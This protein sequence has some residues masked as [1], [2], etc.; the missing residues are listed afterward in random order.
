M[1]IRPP[2]LLQWQIKREGCTLTVSG[3][4]IEAQYAAVFL[5]NT[6]CDVEA[7]TGTLPVPGRR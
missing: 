6:F 5:D 1:G 7:Q 3:M 4:G 2:H